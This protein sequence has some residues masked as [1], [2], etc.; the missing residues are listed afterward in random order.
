MGEYVV[1]GG[2]PGKQRGKVAWKNRRIV[3]PQRKKSERRKSAEKRRR[4]GNQRRFKT[5]QAQYGL[6]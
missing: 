1:V 4:R 3:R 6:G 5:N 2:S